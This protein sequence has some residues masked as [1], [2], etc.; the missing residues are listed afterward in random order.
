MKKFLMLGCMLAAMAGFTACEDDNTG[1]GGYEGINYIYLSTQEGKT[2]LYETDTDPI[3]VEVMLTAAL[4]EDLVLSFAINGTEGV[5]SIEG[6]PVT[7]KAGEKTEVT[8][9]PRQSEKKATHDLLNLQDSDKDA[10][11]TSIQGA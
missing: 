11:A 1:N 3:V 5:V 7:I 4:Q 9:T 8:I 2:T 6:N 10:S